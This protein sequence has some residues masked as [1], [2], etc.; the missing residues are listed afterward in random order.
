MRLAVDPRKVR[1]E[2]VGEPRGE[3]EPAGGD[4][5]HAADERLLAGVLGEVAAGPCPDRGEDVVEP[6]GGRHHLDA[7][8]RLEEVLDPPA[9]NRVVVDDGNADD[10]GFHVRLWITTYCPRMVPGP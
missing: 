10:S 7:V 5:L 1:L 9:R 2:H 8:A 6:A 3:V 4:L